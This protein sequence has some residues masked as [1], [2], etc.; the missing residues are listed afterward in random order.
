VQQRHT[1]CSVRIS[2]IGIFVLF[3]LKR[4]A[5]CVSV[6]Q[7]YSKRDRKELVCEYISERNLLLRGK[8]FRIADEVYAVDVY[9]FY[10]FI[11]C[12]VSFLVRG[13]AN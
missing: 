6:E 13:C 3:F 7:K 8:I 10:T 5:F 9:H 12:F 2:G 4:L 1:Y 11:V